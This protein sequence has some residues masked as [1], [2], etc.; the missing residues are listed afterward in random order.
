MISNG[1]KVNKFKNSNTKRK[2]HDDWVDDITSQNKRRK[3]P[4]NHQIHQKTPI[5]DEY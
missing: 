2:H 4:R 1:N 5:L 3:K